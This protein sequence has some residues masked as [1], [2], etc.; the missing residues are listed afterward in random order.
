M[1]LDMGM[2]KQK[3]AINIYT[4][5]RSYMKNTNINLSRLSVQYS[6]QC[7]YYF[8]TNNNNF[9]SFITYKIIVVLQNCI[10]K[11]FL[12]NHALDFHILF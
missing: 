12:N 3:C 8:L 10:N 1:L 5:I 2:F 4:H 7:I 11:I 9:T 6:N